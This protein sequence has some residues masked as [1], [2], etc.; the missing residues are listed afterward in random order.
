MKIEI[1]PATIETCRARFVQLHG[2]A[3]IATEPLWLQLVMSAAVPKLRKNNPWELDT[4]HKMLDKLDVPKGDSEDVF[5]IWGR[6]QMALEL[7][8]NLKPVDDGGKAAFVL[9]RTVDFDKA[10]DEWLAT[11]DSATVKSILEGNRTIYKHWW[12]IAQTRAIYGNSQQDT[13]DAAFAELLAQIQAT[14][15]HVHAQLEKLD[16]AI[17]EAR[18]AGAIPRGIRNGTLHPLRNIKTWR[19]GC[20]CTLGSAPNECAEC[21]EGLVNS[22]EKWFA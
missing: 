11:S 18:A 5:S 19:A 15:H 21:T 12:R 2:R 3:P 17:V 22:I 10:Y 7:F 13:K 1:T 6:I 14:G 16:S 4:A 9:A 8:A 20:S